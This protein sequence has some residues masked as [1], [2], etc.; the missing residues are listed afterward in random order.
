MPKYLL[1]NKPRRKMVHMHVLDTPSIYSL[2]SVIPGV[3]P[4]LILAIILGG[5]EY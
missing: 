1:S 5:L 2:R 4:F 3:F